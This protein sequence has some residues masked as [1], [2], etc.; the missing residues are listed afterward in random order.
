MQTPTGTLA[1]SQALRTEPW[2]R[3]D[4]RRAAAAFGKARSVVDCTFNRLKQPRRLAKR[5][6]PGRRKPGGENSSRDC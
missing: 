1:A 4:S 6:P 3:S 2:Q 5:R